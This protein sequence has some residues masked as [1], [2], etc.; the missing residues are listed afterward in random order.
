MQCFGLPVEVL[1]RHGHSGSQIDEQPETL[2]GP[3]V[4][5]EAELYRARSA[6]QR[7]RGVVHVGCLGQICQHAIRGPAYPRRGPGPVGAGP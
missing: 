6:S 3:I 2:W 5:G 7:A 4:R 1:D